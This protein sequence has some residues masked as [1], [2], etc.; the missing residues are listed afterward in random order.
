M[1]RGIV[2]ENVKR[3][4]DERFPSEPNK[5]AKS[6][7]LA[8]AAGTTLSQIQRILTQSVGTSI[9]IIESLAGAFEV[10]PQDLLTPYFAATRAAMAHPQSDDGEPGSVP[11]SA[12]SR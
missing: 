11:L 10:R 2:A 4:M 3:L 8:G 6:R 7:A 1:I 12:R 5:T 9:D